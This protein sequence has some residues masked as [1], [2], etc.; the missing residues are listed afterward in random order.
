MQDLSLHVLDIVENSID[1]GAKNVEISIREDRERDVLTIEIADDGRGMTE[2]VL[3]KAADPFWTTRETRRV[4]LGLS[5]L[6]QAARMAGGALKI[7][8]RPG[9][10][11]TVTATF[12]HSHIDRKP[13]G[14]MADTLLT[15]I[16]AHPGVEFTYSHQSEESQVFLNTKEIKTQL[17]SAPLSSPEGISLLR[18]TL[19][20]MRTKASA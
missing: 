13:L 4:G 9:A 1:A 17:S 11:T 14:N 6:E 12:Q 10:G 19:A 5:L 3:K 7:D 20:T 8:S 2:T 16:V 18:K 15:L